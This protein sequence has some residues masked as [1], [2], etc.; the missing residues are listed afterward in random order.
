MKVGL[1][2]VFVPWTVLSGLPL[3]VGFAHLL[4]HTTQSGNYMLA[5]G[6]AFATAVAVACLRVVALEHTRRR[7]ML[8]PPSEW[9][10]QHHVGF[11]AKLRAG[12]SELL[13]PVSGRACALG[14]W[15]LQ[16][17]RRG[18]PPFLLG[19]GM[20]LA[21]SELDTALGRIAIRGTPELSE[22]EVNDLHANSVDEWHRLASYLLGGEV[23]L[24][25]DGVGDS[26]VSTISD[27]TRPPA[28]HGALVAGGMYGGA[29]ATALIPPIPWQ[30]LRKRVLQ[31]DSD[32]A[33]RQLAESIQASG[34]VVVESTLAV[35]T[36]VCVF[37][38]W[39]AA[40]RAIQFDPNHR[41]G[42]HGILG[43]SARDLLARAQ[44]RQRN[45]GAIA[46]LLTTAVVVTLA[47][48]W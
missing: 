48:I 11:G 27:S 45:M 38:T 47:I 37:G 24:P 22:H 9:K 13:S 1:I 29:I 32:M 14:F 7:I 15:Q 31:G 34:V 12:D 18:N 20:L 4:K 6:F 35:G 41:G 21:A 44:R 17:P 10:D 23:R 43:V 40:S 28:L 33:T 8:R 36:E 5:A 39:Q 30:S 26:P 16:V 3:F 46:A 25:A 42:W 19:Q 2:G